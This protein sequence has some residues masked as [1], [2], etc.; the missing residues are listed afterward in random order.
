MAYRCY[1]D[2]LRVYTPADSELLTAEGLDDVASEAGERGT[3]VVAGDF[4]LRPGEQHTI[5]LRYR[6]PATVPV[7][8]Y[9]LLV[10][11]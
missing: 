3:T 7:E 2:Y 11:K 5:M 8:P 6:L 9:R 10:R 4:V 1:W